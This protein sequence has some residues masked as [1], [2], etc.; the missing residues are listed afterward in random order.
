MTAE[1]TVQMRGGGLRVPRSRGAL[2]G[3]LL[4]LLG[5]W[6]ALVP[7]IGPSFNFAYTPDSS[8]TWTAARGWLELLP[9]AVVGVGG[10]LLLMTRNRAVGHLGAW[11]GILGGAWFVIGPQLADLMNIGSVGTPTGSSTG[12]RTLEALAYFYALGAIIVFLASAA[13]GRLSV[14]TVSDLRA[15]QRRE[16]EAVAPAGAP[17]APAGAPVASHAATPEQPVARE[18]KRHSLRHFGRRRHQD[19]EVPQEDTASSR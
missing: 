6:G 7:F 3:V 2:G 11:M 13:F 19:V 14:R 16:A 15:A 9:G 5:A 4:V 1:P 18:Q 8:W 12:M 17:V 10:L